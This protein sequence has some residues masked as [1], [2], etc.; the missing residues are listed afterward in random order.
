[1]ILLNEGKI[2]NVKASIERYIQ[3]NLSGTEG[4][5]IDYEG[6]SGE[7]FSSDEWVQERILGPTNHR[8]HRG[9]GG[10]RRGQGESIIL[11]LNVFVNRQKTK[12]TNRHYEIRDLI[13]KH[14]YVGKDIDLYDFE[15]GNFTTSIQ[16]MR[17]R[18]VVTD[19]PIPDDD[20]FQWNYTVGI[21]WMAKWTV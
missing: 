3:A 14:F 2:Q 7:P 20:F 15:N 11:N 13:V 19:E 10:S 12:K 8:Y 5:T 9:I 1:M 21:D 4:L 6:K 16:K 17:V 18:E